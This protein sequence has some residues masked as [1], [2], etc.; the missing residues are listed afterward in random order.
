MVTPFPISFTYLF[1][2]TF[3]I[4]LF[5]IFSCK[6][7]FRLNIVST[8]QA[9]LFSDY[10]NSYDKKSYLINYIKVAVTRIDHGNMKTKQLYLA[11]N[12]VIDM[13][14]KTFT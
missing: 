3:S 13:E 1:P 8:L 4:S 14:T 9:L 6:T 5:C 11:V 10:G 12:I 7:K 2:M